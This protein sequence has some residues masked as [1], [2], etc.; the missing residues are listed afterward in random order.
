MGTLCQLRPGKLPSPEM[1]RAVSGRARIMQRRQIKEVIAKKP[2]IQR[3]LVS[4]TRTPPRMGPRLG[5][6][7]GLSWLDLIVRHR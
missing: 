3:Q 2:K 4:C 5:A 1:E 6:R 7:F